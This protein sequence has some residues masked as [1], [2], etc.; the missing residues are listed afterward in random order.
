M[1]FDDWSMIELFYGWTNPFSTKEFLLTTL[2][3]VKSWLFFKQVLEYPLIF[4]FS[5]NPIFMVF[6]DYVSR[7]IFKK[8]FPIQSHCSK[9]KFSID[10]FSSKN[11][12]PVHILCLIF[13]LWVRANSLHEIHTGRAEMKNC[14]RS[15]FF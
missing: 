12:C 5:A 14:K 13:F 7:R 15:C 1:I 10:I 6:E 2:S 9:K 11:T 3:F 8:S 4:T